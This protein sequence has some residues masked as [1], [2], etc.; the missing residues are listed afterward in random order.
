MAYSNA[1]ICEHFY[2]YKYGKW[3]DVIYSNNKLY[4]FC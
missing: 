3:G 4:F 2:P 1:Q